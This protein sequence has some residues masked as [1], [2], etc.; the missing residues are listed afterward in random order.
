MDAAKIIT[1]LN[2][3]EAAANIILDELQKTKKL[4]DP[5]KIKTKKG[6][7]TE[8]ARNRVREKSMKSFMRYQNKFNS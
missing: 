2:N 5:V 1:R 8:E 3:L 6:E 4:L 7:W